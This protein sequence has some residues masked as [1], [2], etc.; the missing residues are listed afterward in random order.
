LEN[1]LLD[2]AIRHNQGAL[3]VRTVGGQ[4]KLLYPPLSLSSEAFPVRNWAARC[5]VS[6][7][8]PLVGKW[9]KLSQEFATGK[10]IRQDH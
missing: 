6:I 3:D 10:E 1:V 2:T 9:N 5:Q 8:K 4:Y 7:A